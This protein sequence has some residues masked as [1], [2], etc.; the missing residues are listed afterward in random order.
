MDHQIAKDV[1]LE[2]QKRPFYK[3]L[4]NWFQAIADN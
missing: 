4:N 3:E 2:I 1:F